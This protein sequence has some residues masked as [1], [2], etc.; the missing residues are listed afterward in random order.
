MRWSVGGGGGGGGGGGRG[1]GASLAD[2]DVLVSHTFAARYGDQREAG[3]ARGRRSRSGRVE[4]RRNA[5]KERACVLGR[6]V[7]VCRE[8]CRVLKTTADTQSAKCAS[9]CRRYG[10][11]SLHHCQKLTNGLTHSTPHF[12]QPICNVHSSV[13]SQSA[14]CGQVGTPTQGEHLC[15]TSCRR[16]LRQ[17][18]LA[19]V[20]NSVRAVR[21]CCQAAT[22]SSAHARAALRRPPALLPA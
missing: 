9:S 21:P 13:W 17:L 8:S 10:R 16:P 22:R 6:V 18:R 7:W 15:S 12:D 2:P 4:G 5:A 19:A 3:A 1:P 11:Q 14:S 20:W